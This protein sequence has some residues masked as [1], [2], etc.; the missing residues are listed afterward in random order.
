MS[1][2]AEIGISNGTAGAQGSIE[3]M[4][5]EIAAIKNEIKLT[6]GIITNKFHDCQSGKEYKVTIDSN[7]RIF[8]QN[9]INKANFI[10]DQSGTLH[11]GLGHSFLAKGKAVNAAG[12]IKINSRGLVRS[13]CNLSGHYQPTIPETIRYLNYMSAKGYVKPSTWITIYSFDSNKSG[14]ITKKAVVYNGPYKYLNRRFSH[15][16]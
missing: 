3:Q 11:I 4:N 13:I 2:G 15:E 8:T 10:I 14:Y 16:A 9:G 5:S 1:S 12:I 7:N 6:E